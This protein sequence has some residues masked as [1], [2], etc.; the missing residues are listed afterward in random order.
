MPAPT[1]LCK[2]VLRNVRDADGLSAGAGETL[3]K[4]YRASLATAVGSAGRIMISGSAGG[5]SYSFGGGYSIDRL[6]DAIDE[7]EA[8]WNSYTTAQMALLLDHR[9][10]RTVQVTFGGTRLSNCAN[11]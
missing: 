2:T 6:T 10:L 9:P 7:A 1:P 5:K 4:S 11:H 8:I 3:L